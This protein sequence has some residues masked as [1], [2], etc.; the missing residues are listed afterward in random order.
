MWKHSRLCYPKGRRERNLYTLNDARYFGK[1]FLNNSLSWAC[2]AGFIVPI[3]SFGKLKAERERE[4]AAS[5]WHLSLSISRGFQMRKGEAKGA[6]S[7]LSTLSSPSYS[8]HYL[9]TWENAQL[10]WL[11]CRQ[12]KADVLLP[13]PFRAW[14]SL[15]AGEALCPRIRANFPPAPLKSTWRWYSSLT[16]RR[17]L[18]S[19]R[20]KDFRKLRS[21]PIVLW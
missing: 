18:P 7:Q 1:Y 5:T 9:N 3:L 2:E 13:S 11:R 19:F 10:L 17:A 6:H 21:S 4:L 12:Y 14:G 8:L 15:V 16:V 20:A